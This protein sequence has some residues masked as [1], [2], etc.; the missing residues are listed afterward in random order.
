MVNDRTIVQTEIAAHEAQL[1]GPMR[2]F[3][4]TSAKAL[5]FYLATGKITVAHQLFNAGNIA[6]VHGTGMSSR[7]SEVDAQAAEK[8]IDRLASL[9]AIKYAERNDIKALQEVFAAEAARTDGG[10]GIE[11]IMKTHT[12]LQ[13]ESKDKL[14][15]GSETL[16]MKG[17]VPEIYDPYM[18]VVMATDAEGVELELRGY[19][20]MPGYLGQDDADTLTDKKR[21]YSL[22]DGGM[23][24][25]NSGIFSTKD[26]R[27]KGNKVVA[28]AVSV[29][30]AGQQNAAN[31][32]SI[33]AGKRADIQA[34]FTG[35]AF[36]PLQ[37]K[38]TYMAPVLSPNGDVT[39]YRYMMS[40]TVKDKLLNRD[41]R[42][43]KLLGAMAGN[44]FD[45][46]TSKVQNRNAVQA[47]HEQYLADYAGNVE[48][49]LTV[50]PNSSDPQLREIWHML[51][52][53]TQEQAKALFGPHGMKVRNDVLDINFGYRKLSIGTVFDKEA[54]QRNFVENMFVEIMTHAFGEKAQL[55]TRQTEDIWQAIV[56]ETKA[57]LVVKSWSTMTGNLRSNWSQ[58][59]MMGVSPV[60]IF[61]SHRVA[62]KAA[63]EYKQDNAKLF[64]LKHQQQIGHLE[65]GNTAAKVAYQ[66]KRLEDSLARNP[67]RPL[68][69]AG[70]MPT[71]VED[72]SVDEDVYSYKSRFTEKID[73]VVDAVNPHILKG[74]QLL[75]MHHST[76]PYKV[77][78]YAT[79]I[80]DFLARYTLYQH[81]MTKKNALTHE[82]AVQRASEAFINYDVPTHR[83]IQYAN[84][85]GLIMFSKYYIRI[86]KVLARIYK[87][88]PGRV[89]AIMAAEHMLGDQPTV[90][91]SGF[92]HHFGNPFNGGALSYFSSLD[93]VTSV[94]LITGPFTTA[95]YN[96]Q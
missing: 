67:I 17:Y 10:H 69:D 29:T 72:V 9:Y 68:I 82:Q 63:W 70:L 52:R 28:G 65:P 58:L 53:D 7:V 38:A 42:T 80:S 76:A 91:D 88:S 44:T 49:Y 81:D 92:T 83:K 84:D 14:F 35:T 1:T 39:N 56:K 40:N 74:L 12:S 45:K 43:G 18:S 48:S 41:N 5:G 13:A 47:L 95:A 11:M 79:Q 87:D 62:F 23:K 94:A 78:S 15:A 22:R 21:I 50:G 31:M 71:I 86:Q 85:S 30:A 16:Q 89:L 20:P 19:V 26:S 64:Q 59:F 90:L 34:M 93:S 51:P 4:T 25:W 8:I 33:A 6:R 46:V 27:A 3:Y 66:I 73:G 54:A 2:R 37:V 77:M 61:K 75:T 24:Q 96:G 55:R 36:D 57:N 32:A 60:Q